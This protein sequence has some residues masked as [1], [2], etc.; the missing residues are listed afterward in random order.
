MSM[1]NLKLNL[2]EVWGEISKFSNGKTKKSVDC[3]YLNND[4]SRMRFVILRIKQELRC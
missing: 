3:E 2:P 4:A 1:N